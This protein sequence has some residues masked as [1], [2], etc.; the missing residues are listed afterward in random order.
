MSKCFKAEV[1]K[2]FLAA[3][4]RSERYRRRF[5]KYTNKPMATI[6]T[7]LRDAMSNDGEKTT[8]S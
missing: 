6:A 5:S 8:G 1:G 4:W 7:P 2:A 3:T